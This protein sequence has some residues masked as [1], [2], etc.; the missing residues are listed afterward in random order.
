MIVMMV[1]LE[2]FDLFF[3][4]KVIM[5]LTLFIDLSLL[6]ILQVMYFLQLNFEYFLIIFL[7]IKDWLLTF[8]LV[9]IYFFYMINISSPTTLFI[10]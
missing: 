2:V 10:T 7:F 5:I 4:V 6:T 8:Q 3:H 9:I 1:L